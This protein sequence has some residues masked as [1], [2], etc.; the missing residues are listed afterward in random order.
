MLHHPISRHACRSV[1]CCEPG[2][3]QKDALYFNFRQAPHIG[4]TW[5]GRQKRLSLAITSYLLTGC[6]V[7]GCWPMEITRRPV[8]I[9]SRGACVGL[10]GGRRRDGGHGGAFAASRAG[11]PGRADLGRTVPLPHGRPADRHLSGAHAVSSSN[12]HYPAGSPSGA[13][14]DDISSGVFPAFLRQA[15]LLTLQLLSFMPTAL[16]QHPT[17]ITKQ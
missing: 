4:H 17:L 7:C 10:R 9:E 6:L 2:R 8:A 16:T 13:A 11:A 15:F 14:L 5:Q 1:I 12:C 3:A